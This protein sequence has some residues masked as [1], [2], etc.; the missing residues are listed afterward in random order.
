MQ[1]IAVVWLMHLQ[2][3]CVG[4]FQP[5]A[6]ARQHHPQPHSRTT[7]CQQYSTAHPHRLHTK[8]SRRSGTAVV[9]SRGINPAAAASLQR[10]SR[11]KAG[12]PTP[13]TPCPT[14]APP[15]LPA[16]AAAVLQLLGCQQVIH[17]NP[18]LA[19]GSTSVAHQTQH[20][21]AW[22]GSSTRTRGLQGCS[23]RGTGWTK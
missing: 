13:P 17:S 11:S 14:A 19:K 18:M 12:R 4:R 6:A 10:S 23:L 9:A 5:R 22:H 20:I 15:P 8:G 1:L 7:N 16:A 21:P 2:V 3:C